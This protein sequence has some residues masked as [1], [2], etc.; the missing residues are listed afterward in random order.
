MTHACPQCGFILLDSEE[1]VEACPGCGAAWTQAARVELRTS[2]ETLPVTSGALCGGRNRGLWFAAFVLGLLVGVGG[3]QFM[4]PT[5]A[6]TESSILASNA[7]SA[8]A[9]DS[10]LAVARDDAAIQQVQS[11]L[12]Q[13]QAARDQA[14]AQRKSAEAA[15][16]QAEQRLRELDRIHTESLEML[17]EV[18]AEHE[19]LQERFDLQQAE[20]ELQATGGSTAFI[21]R[22]QVLGPLSEAQTLAARNTIEREPFRA[23]VQVE[24]LRGPTGWKLHESSDDRI[25]LN[26]ACESNDQ[27]ASCWLTCWVYASAPRKLHL[28]LGSDDGF[29][30]WLNREKAIERRGLRPATPGQDRVLVELRAGWNQLLAHVDNSGGSDWGFYCEFRAE[31]GDAPV[32]VLSSPTPPPRRE[33][34]PET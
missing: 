32:R 33:R 16:V 22:W 14:I 19:V 26:R 4:L 9:V 10:V 23:D 25:H 7:V 27:G 3:M 24:G 31:M 5:L 12:R 2:A 20:L 30:L 34:S 21:R 11:E 13:V 15:S 17:R 1:P 6:P 29:A 28:S 18:Q 8:S